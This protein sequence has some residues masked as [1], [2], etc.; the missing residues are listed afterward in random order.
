MFFLNLDL[1]NDSLNQFI[2]IIN[3]FYKKTPYSFIL[4]SVFIILVDINLYFIS[5]KFISF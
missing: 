3:H 5:F 1:I 4:T 2:A